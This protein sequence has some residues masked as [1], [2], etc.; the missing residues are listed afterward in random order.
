MD[1]KDSHSLIKL[2]GGFFCR[3]FKYF[4]EKK[5]RWHL[6]KTQYFLMRRKKGITLQII[7]NACD[8]SISLLSLYENDK[9]NM[10]QEKVMKYKEFIANY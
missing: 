10:E 3:S 2:R 9:A 8:C 1:R 7:A 6:E 4:N 5:G